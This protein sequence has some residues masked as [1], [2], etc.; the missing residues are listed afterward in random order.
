MDLSIPAALFGLT[1][2]RA[3]LI[4]SV[5]KLPERSRSSWCTSEVSHHRGDVSG[6]SIVRIGESSIADELRGDGICCYGA[7]R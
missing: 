4:S 2:L 1:H 3:V 5:E 7:H 6:E